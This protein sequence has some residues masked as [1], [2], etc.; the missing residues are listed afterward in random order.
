[1]YHSQNILGKNFQNTLK[2]KKAMGKKK[3]AMVSKQIG[4]H[5][6][7]RRRKRRK[8][9]EKKKNEEQ[10]AYKTEINPDLNLPTIDKYFKSSYIL[11]IRQILMQNDKK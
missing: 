5:S 3:K 10:R 2:Q 11:F 7:G 1:M 9:R 4:K 6:I 8:R